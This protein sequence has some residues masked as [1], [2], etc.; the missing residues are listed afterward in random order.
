MSND[1]SSLFLSSDPEDLDH[2]G[3]DVNI[4]VGSNELKVIDSRPDSVGPTLIKMISVIIY[5]INCQSMIIWNI[6]Y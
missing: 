6:F 2:V 3:D 1:D 4:S 5:Q